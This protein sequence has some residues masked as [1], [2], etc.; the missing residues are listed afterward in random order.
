[1]SS[2]AAGEF[3]F[4][5]PLINSPLKP[6][7]IYSI[8]WLSIV[9]LLGGACVQASYKGEADPRAK[10]IHLL[11]LSL[12]IT[13]AKKGI[14]Q[15]LSDENRGFWLSSWK[16][17]AT[18]RKRY[19][20]SIKLFPEGVAMTV[21]VQNDIV[22]RKNPTAVAFL[23]IGRPLNIFKNRLWTT[24]ISL[25]QQAQEEEKELADEISITWK[26]LYRAQRQKSQEE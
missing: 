2:L 20:F 9:L 15:K 18:G 26:Q 1:M 11:W 12:E 14:T 13:A 19:S 6:K 17:T 24:D 5:A 25:I 16:A 22:D 8:L 21:R 23:V 4:L 7:V 10:D 3:Y